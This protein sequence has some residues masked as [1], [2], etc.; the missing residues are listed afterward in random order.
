MGVDEGN[1]QVIAADAMLQNCLIPVTL[2]LFKEKSE[3]A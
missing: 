1:L 2:L 3:R